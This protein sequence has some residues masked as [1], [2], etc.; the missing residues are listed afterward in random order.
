MVY[1]LEANKNSLWENSMECSRV[2]P[3][4]IREAGKFPAYCNECKKV[5][6]TGIWI[7]FVCVCVCV[8]VVCVCAFVFILYVNTT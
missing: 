5:P 4:N 8:H 6:S 1:V 3:S 2:N 7:F